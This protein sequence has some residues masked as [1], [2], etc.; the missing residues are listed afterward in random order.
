MSDS[1]NIGRAYQEEYMVAEVACPGG[2][3]RIEI[4]FDD[5]P[6]FNNDP[7]AYAAAHFNLTRDE[8][9]EWVALDG[10]PWCG[11]MTKTGRPCKNFVGRIQHRAAEWKQKHRR[12]ACKAHKGQPV[13]GDN[14]T[15]E[16]LAAIRDDREA[17]TRDYKARI[18]DLF[19]RSLAEREEEVVAA[20]RPALRV[21]GGSEAT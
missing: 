5:V 3:N 10:T 9:R 2:W 20:S 1:I 12:L 16:W 14:T 18:A 4:D 7:D 21:I 8:Y 13:Q 15:T 6:G 11:C 19:A 17:A